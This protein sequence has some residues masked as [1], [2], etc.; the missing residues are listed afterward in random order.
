MQLLSGLHNNGLVWLQSSAC[1]VPSAEDALSLYAHWMLPFHLAGDN[2]KE[3]VSELKSLNSLDHLTIPP[4]TAQVSL[5]IMLRY[6]P[7]LISTQHL[8]H[9]WVCLLSLES[10]LRLDEDAV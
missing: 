9:L 3:T 5:Q 2:S 8:I 6:L 10:N 4:K 1:I 7:I